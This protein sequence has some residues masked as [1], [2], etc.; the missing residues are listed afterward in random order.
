[1]TP[2]ARQN[3]FIVA[4]ICF[5]LF[6]VPV[7][8]VYMV[9]YG[10]VVLG[11]HHVLQIRDTVDKTNSTVTLYDIKANFFFSFE[12]NKPFFYRGMTITPLKNGAEMRVRSTIWRL[13]FQ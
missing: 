6:V 4:A 5:I 3:W 13:Y 12:R 1:M 8:K 7:E 10:F 9:N 2:F 11:G